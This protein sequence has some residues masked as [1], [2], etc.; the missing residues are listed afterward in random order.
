[1]TI[2]P[3][4][5]ARGD[6]ADVF[7][8]ESDT[9]TVPVTVQR[10][11]TTLSLSIPLA[12]VTVDVI[13]AAVVDAVGQ[14]E[15]VGA[16][17]ELVQSGF[18]QACSD[19]YDHLRTVGK[20]DGRILKVTIQSLYPVAEPPAEPPETRIILDD[21]LVGHLVPALGDDELL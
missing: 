11:T 9:V 5:L 14:V 15:G 21:N 17:I 1:M 8:A 19:Y 16:I 12:S 7:I 18:G 13:E 3:N 6:A 4:C 10:G 2:E 20:V